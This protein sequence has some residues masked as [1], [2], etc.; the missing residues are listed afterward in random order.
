MATQIIIKQ[1]GI[2]N[3]KIKYIEMIK[4]LNLSIY[5]E[6][7]YNKERFIV[8]NRNKVGFG[9]LIDITEKKEIF[10]LL[11]KFVTKT[12]IEDLYR[13]INY[14]CEEI[15]KYEIY[16]FDQYITLSS[17]EIIKDKVLENSLLEL[18]IQCK[19]TV[20]PLTKLNL[21]FLDYKVDEEFRR[22]FSYCD[23]LEEI[24]KYIHCI[25]KSNIF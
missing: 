2:F 18:Q 12:E 11:S 5:K 16:I 7:I 22:K 19:R 21:L 3:K 14:I 23:N 25:Q 6:D 10:F 15:K 9:I 20:I 8:F 24:E 1:K 13:M 4:H 17:L